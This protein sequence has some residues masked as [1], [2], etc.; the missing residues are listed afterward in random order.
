MAFKMKNPMLAKAA[1]KASTP[2]QANYSPMKQ[3]KPKKEATNEAVVEAKMQ[4]AAEARANQKENQNTNVDDLGTKEEVVTKAKSPMMQK[5]PFSQ[6][7]VEK[8]KKEAST[9]VLEIVKD[10][11]TKAADVVGKIKTGL[12]KIYQT[13]HKK[14]IAEPTTLQALGHA[15]AQILGYVGGAG[16]QVI[17]DLIRPGI[18]DT[19]ETGTK[20]LFK[21]SGT[22]AKKPMK[23]KSPAKAKKPMKAKS[24]TKAKKPMK[25]K[26]PVKAKKP[27]KAK[28]PTKFNAKLKAASAAGQLSGKFKKLVDNS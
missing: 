8:T 5:Q 25:A 27:M 9:D 24:P 26:S 15:P 16:A 1:S 13:S 12:G 17:E 14:A 21:K 4:A 18:Q 6:K 3:R 23:A 11:R 7:P 22:K 10:V 20:K 28:S 19:F 2:M